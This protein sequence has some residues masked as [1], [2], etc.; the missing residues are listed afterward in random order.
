MY[1]CVCEGF[2][3]LF[4]RLVVPSPKIVLYICWVH[5]ALLEADMGIMLLQHEFPD[6]KGKCENVTSVTMRGT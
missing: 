5:C 3:H 2:P 4:E 1:T 6:S